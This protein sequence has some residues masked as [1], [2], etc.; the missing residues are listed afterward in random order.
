MEGMTFEC[1]ACI[2]TR[3]QDEA[4][5]FEGVRV[6]ASCLL[7]MEARQDTET[8]EFTFTDADRRA[9]YPTVE[10]KMSDFATWVYGLTG[11]RTACPDPCRTER[12]QPGTSVA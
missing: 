12:F 3:P 2:Q 10:L 9:L 8:L 11:V 5:V 7:D 1:P 4:W 6:C